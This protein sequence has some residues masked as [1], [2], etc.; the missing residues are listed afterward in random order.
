[1]E[2]IAFT[3]V[4][5]AGARNRIMR[6]ENKYRR[7]EQGFSLIELMIVIAI[8]GILVGV[9]VP[10]WK[11]A[12]IAGNETAAIQTLRTIAAE[13]RMYYIRHQQYA[14]FDQLKERG[15]LNEKFAGDEPSQNGYVF[16]MKVT[17]KAPSQQPS[18]TVNAE[19]LDGGL[20]SPTGERSFY[21]DS[22]ISTPRVLGEEASAGTLEAAPPAQ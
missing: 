22:N 15:A 13:Q 10:M 17:P 14:T 5:E 3:L 21:I 7:V 12:M 18:Y 6:I 11:N 20:A 4:Y 1:M 19:P 2:P 16:R 9:G 8:I